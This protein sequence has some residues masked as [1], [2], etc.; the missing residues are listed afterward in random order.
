VSSS[1][2][3]RTIHWFRKDLRITDNTGLRHASEISDDV[4]PFYSLSTWKN[5]HNWTGAPRQQFLCECLE[6][7]D[8]NLRSIGSQL[9]IRHG[10][11][12]EE[13]TKLIE[14]SDATAITFN[15]DG[16][17][18][19]RAEEQQ[20]EE[21]C[22]DRGIA[23]LGF[24][25]AVM[26][27]ADEVLKSDGTPYRVYTPYSKAW[28]KLDKAKARGRLRALTMPQDIE[29]EELPTLDHWEIS[30]PEEYQHTTLGGEKEARKR[31]KRAL[32]GIVQ[33]YKNTRNT[34]HGITTS[35]LGQDLRHG[36]ISIRELYGKVEHILNSTTSSSVRESAGT[37][38]NEL[39]W[40]E[41][42]MQIL[43]HYPHV[44]DQPFNEKYKGLWWSEAEVAFERWCQG[45]TGFPIVDAGIRELR[46]TG[47]MHNR[48]R[49]I[50]AMFL[51]KDL[52]IHWRRGEAFFM[53][54]LLDGEIA[55]N[56]GGWQWSAGT[57]ADAA[58]Y[59]R[60]QNPWSQ[61]KRYAADG[62]YIK[63]WVPELAN[64]DSKLFLD[65]PKDGSPIADDYPLPMVDHSE[66]RERTLAIF[67]Q[68]AE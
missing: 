56:N 32:D 17:P 47:F 38:I 58:P 15:R 46:A 11:A 62:E 25:D 66:E 9:I 22:R 21:F 26:H 18:F 7:L 68:N 59:F 57:G 27:S 51:T 53:Q 48:L 20:L 1:L 44:Y 14:Q 19:G 61:T 16:D 4:I 3:H 67:K 35:R 8:A 63:Q 65:P 10:S 52:H 64:C 60:I 23:C 43:V 24:I 5:H 28:K 37:F 2:H 13:I 49:M 12:F 33:D 50:V 36:T 29:S 34:P 55:S 41:F 30:L 54:W 42:Y 40:R 6:S 45:K 39:A 31:M